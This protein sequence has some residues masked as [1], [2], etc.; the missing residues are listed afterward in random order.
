MCILKKQQ[1]NIAAISHYWKH[2]SDVW[3][4]LQD[5]MCIDL[6]NE[7]KGEQM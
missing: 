1:M 6:Q 7:S 5:L 4:S 3:G 2:G